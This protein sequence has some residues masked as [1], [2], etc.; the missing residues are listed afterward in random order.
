M[1]HPAR[2]VGVA[3]SAHVAE[4]LP[5]T[6]AGA[7]LDLQRLS[8]LVLRDDPSLLQDL[9]EGLVLSTNPGAR[10]PRCGGRFS[11]L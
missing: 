3:D 6:F 10:R 1:G 11:L 8:E 7:G 9:P 2:E 4:D 5:D